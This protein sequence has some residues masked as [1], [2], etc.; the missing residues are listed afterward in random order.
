MRKAIRWIL[1]AVRDAAF[2]VLAPDRLELDRE[3]D[4]PAADDQ[5]DGEE[6]SRKPETAGGVGG[7][8]HDAGKAPGR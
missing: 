4:D 1:W 3:L 2:L 8:N 5:P 6:Q 7:F